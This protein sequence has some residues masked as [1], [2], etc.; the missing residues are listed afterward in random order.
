MS[1]YTPGPWSVSYSKFDTIEAGNGA[2]LAKCIRISSLV[3]LQA[4]ARLMAAA[5]ELLDIALRLAGLET[6]LQNGN[7]AAEHEACRIATDARRV[8]AKATGGEA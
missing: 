3:T 8:V 5:P 2:A 7:S 6:A 1:T 4:N